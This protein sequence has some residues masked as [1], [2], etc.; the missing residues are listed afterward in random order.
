MRTTM[1]PIAAM[2]C[3]AEVTFHPTQ[4]KT[5]IWPEIGYFVD[6][7]LSC[8][9]NNR[10]RR[11]KHFGCCIV[12][13]VTTQLSNCNCDKLYY[14]SRH[15]PRPSFYH[16]TKIQYYRMEIAKASGCIILSLVFVFDSLTRSTAVKQKF[17]T[18]QTARPSKYST[19]DTFLLIL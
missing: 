18:M 6:I 11:S 5:Q 14:V 1:L 16:V 2:R 12:G 8:V 7:S 9:Q 15:T 10:E 19:E 13:V 3:D 17:G 4:I